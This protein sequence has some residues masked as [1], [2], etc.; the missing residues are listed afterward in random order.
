MSGILEDVRN[1]EDL[2]EIKKHYEKSLNK[3]ETSFEE[4]TI[5][6]YQNLISYLP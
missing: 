1:L 2:E 5:E 3:P 6:D 4:Y